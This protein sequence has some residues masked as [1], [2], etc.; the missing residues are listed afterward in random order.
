MCADHVHECMFTMLR[1]DL[2]YC[3]IW[4][5]VHVICGTTCHYYVIVFFSFDWYYHAMSVNML[6]TACM[7]SIISGQRLIYEAAINL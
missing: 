1:N 2:V 4:V 3:A 6:S 7:K 5:I